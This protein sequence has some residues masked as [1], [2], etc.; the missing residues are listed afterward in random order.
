MRLFETSTAISE[1]KSLFV[2]L[3]QSLRETWTERMNPTKATVTSPPVEVSELWSKRRSGMPRLVSGL[4]HGG[5]ITLALIPWATAPK[6]IPKGTVDIA[7]Y[8]P[9][10]LVLNS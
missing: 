7:L 4:L 6:R 5:L 3:I 10:Q 1:P 9:Q 2:R 8:T